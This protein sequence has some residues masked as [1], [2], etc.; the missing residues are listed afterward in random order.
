MAESSISFK[1]EQEMCILFQNQFSQCCSIHADSN[2]SDH[3]RALQMH[4]KI[5]NIHAAVILLHVA[6]IKW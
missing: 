5:D 6:G 4:F 2:T 1:A 3:Q